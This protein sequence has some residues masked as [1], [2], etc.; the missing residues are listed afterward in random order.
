[1][2]AQL[3]IVPTIPI[4]TGRRGGLKDDGGPTIFL[5]AAALP[6]AAHRKLVTPHRRTRSRDEPR[7]P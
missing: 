7:N 1:M 2:R 6:P 4:V 3:S 5:R